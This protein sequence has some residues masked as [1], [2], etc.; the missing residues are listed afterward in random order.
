MSTTSTTI[1]SSRKLI[2]SFIDI[3]QM[4]YNLTTDAAKEYN[5]W[6]GAQLLGHALGYNSRNLIKPGAIRHNLYLLLVGESTK[7][8]KTTSQN[9]AKDVYPAIS[10]IHV[11]ASPERFISEL[12]ENSHRVL[13]MGEFSGFL[14][15]TQRGGYMSPMIEYFND[16]YD[17]PREITP[18]ALVENKNRQSTFTIKNSY[19][20]IN[21]TVTPEMLR[22]TI[23]PELIYGGFLV[24]WVLVYGE[25][26]DTDRELLD[27][28]AYTYEEAIRASLETINRWVQAGKGLTFQFTKSCLARYNEI[29]R[30][31][32]KIGLTVEAFAGR[33]MDVMI[34]VADILFVSD[35]IGPLFMNPSLDRDIIPS[36]DEAMKLG[37]AVPNDKGIFLI[38]TKYIE[39][40]WS[41][42]RPCL[43]YARGMADYVSFE[44]PTAKL[45][46]ELSKRAPRTH[47]DVMRY[48]RLEA[49]RMAHAVQTLAEQKWLLRIPIPFTSSRGTTGY[50]L[51]YCRHD[52]LNSTVCN[53]CT[54]RK[55][56]GEAEK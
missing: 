20:S 49:T 30:E 14:K 41:K 3:F 31:A 29:A 52:L 7:P 17:C 21:S 38:D 34:K 1:V 36:L 25:G 4:Y 45:H 26:R 11:G 53:S 39:E 12:S 18:R 13:W 44:L 32:R 55:E 50:A 47:S 28:N 42:I 10:A 27:P 6:L 5:W 46:A 2:K 8:R 51:S 33:Y 37:G 9:L 15:K 24:R 40:A 43:E 22:E 16:F 23:T 19:L 56:C 54:I 48:T 35:V